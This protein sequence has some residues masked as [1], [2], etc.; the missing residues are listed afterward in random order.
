MHFVR[1]YYNLYGDIKTRIIV[2]IISILHYYLL[3]LLWGYD[4]YF[5]TV[6]TLPTLLE[7]V[8]GLLQSVHLFYIYEQVL[9]F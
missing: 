3:A 6:L 7:Y 1:G 9:L 5:F 8:M 4:F 2:I